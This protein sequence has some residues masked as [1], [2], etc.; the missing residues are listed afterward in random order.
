MLRKTA[1]AGN[2]LQHEGLSMETS[3]ALRGLGMGEAVVRSSRAA[4]LSGKLF[5]DFSKGRA[6]CKRL[7][8]TKACGVLSRTRRC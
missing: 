4:L 6:A 8:E 1:H 2:G 5:V 3:A 7:Q